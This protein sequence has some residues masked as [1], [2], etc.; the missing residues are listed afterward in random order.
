M[1][2]ALALLVVDD[3]LI[4]RLAIKRA[5]RSTERAIAVTETESGAGALA[6]VEA[7]H[8]DCI[9]LDY[10]LPDADALSV[11]GNI[12]GRGC[13][14]PIVVL[15]GQGDERI[16]VALM[17]A[18]ATDYLTKE[19]LSPGRLLQSVLAAVRVHEAE[20][21]AER[22]LQEGLDRL[23]FQS[24]ASHILSAS[25]D[26]ATVIANLSRLLVP[27]L[28]DWC[29]VRLLGGDGGYYQ[30]SIYPDPGADLR[31]AELTARLGL[32][33][34]Q[35]ISP[36]LLAGGA[37]LSFPD[38][39]GGPVMLTPGEG[40]DAGEDGPSSLLCVPINGNG[41][42][43]GLFVLARHRER[44]VFTVTEL[45]L[46]QDLAQ[47]LA[48]ALHN[49]YL[50]VQ[51]HDALRLRDEFVSIAAHELRTPLTGLL[52]YVQLLDQRLRRAYDLA[53]REARMLRTI[54]EQ[55]MRLNEQ[56][57]RLLDLSNMK[58]GQF[59]LE[60][61]P[62]DLGA[63]LARVVDRQRDGLEHHAINLRLPDERFEVLGDEGRLEQA[64]E[65]LLH[66][67]VKYSPHGGHI[68]LR[69]SLYNQWAHIVVADKGIGIPS[70][71]MPNLFHRF[72]R[73]KNA[74]ELA[75]SGIGLGLYLVNEIV[76]LHGGVIEVQSEVGH[77]SSFTVRLPLLRAA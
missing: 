2:G 14:A 61:R 68:V 49:A 55:G 40:S 64:F 41:Q 54:L 20:R 31:S 9:L 30:A 4:D 70:D 67:A 60:R 26:Q 58:S 21:Q 52:G 46:A 72:Y 74:D 25:L 50:Y 5:L 10:R 39:T 22:A 13:Y 23:R 69:A 24:E 36:D 34:P 45:A 15:T 47:R 28:A 57:T 71:A 43:L 33:G 8:F 66:N 12:R 6:L 18:G 27:R 48:V 77:G 19:E 29:T 62:I 32:D 37:S 7:E 73:A 65:Q 75:I 42:Q 59:T 38:L 56:V 51:S 63:T 11:V 44:P 76:T 3:D 16:A 1:D 35:P 17:K 53:D